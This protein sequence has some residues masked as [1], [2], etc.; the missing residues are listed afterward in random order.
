M[1][2]RKFPAP[3]LAKPDLSGFKNFFAKRLTSSAEHAKM[4]APGKSE[5]DKPDNIDNL[6]RKDVIHGT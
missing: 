2:S 1:I 5:P 3:M 6:Q 4:V